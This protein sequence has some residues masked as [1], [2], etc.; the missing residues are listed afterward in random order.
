MGSFFY[1]E[2]ELVVFYLEP[3]HAHRYRQ[4]LCGLRTGTGQWVGVQ[5]ES[6][7]PFLIRIV[8]LRIGGKALNSFLSMSKLSDF[9]MA[10]KVLNSK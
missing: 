1:D 2:S 7:I 10:A 6:N 3:A 9:L 8:Y 5:L 4:D